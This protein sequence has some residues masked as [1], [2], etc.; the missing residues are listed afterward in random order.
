MVYDLNISEY[1]ERVTEIMVE[2]FYARNKADLIGKEQVE[3]PHKEAKETVKK[4]MSNMMEGINNEFDESRVDKI[5]DGKR[6]I[7]GKTEE[8]NIGDVF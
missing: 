5:I 6:N 4:V 3:N 2:L 7:D 8:E 1:D